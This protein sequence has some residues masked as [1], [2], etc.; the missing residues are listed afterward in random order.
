[1]TRIEKLARRIGGDAVL[2]GTEDARPLLVCAVGVIAEAAALSPVQEAEV[3]DIL[4]DYLKEQENG[5]NGS[6]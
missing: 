2:A 1:M 4:K 6:L 3:W 5:R